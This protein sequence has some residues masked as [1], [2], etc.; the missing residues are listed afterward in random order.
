MTLAV[1]P[2]IAFLVLTVASGSPAAKNTPAPAAPPAPAACSDFYGHVNQAWLRAHPL[3]LGAPSFSRWDELNAAAVQ[4]TQKLLANTEPPNRGAASVLLATLVVSASDETGLDAAARA[5]AKPL[6]ARID[7]IR[8]PKDVARTIA[9]LHAAGVPVVFGFDALR[10]ADTG[11]ARATFYPGG[12]GLPDPAYYGAVGPELQPAVGLYRAYLGELL[13]FAGV[14][15]AQVAEQ[16]NAAWAIETALA[17]T[18]AAEKDE[19]LAVA[20]L[21]KAYPALF[22]PDFM[23]SQGAAPAVISV[24]GPAFFKALDRMLAK[25]TLAQWQAYLRTQVANSLAPAMARDLRQPYLTALGTSSAAGAAVP[26]SERLA[27]LAEDDALELVSSAYA[28]TY[29]STADEKRADEI[30]ES[31]RVSMGAAIDRASWLSAAGKTAARTKLEA[32]RLAIG[33]PI[34]PVSF[35]DLSFDR[36]NYAGNLLALRRWNRTRSLARL[37]SAVWPWPVSQIQPVI[38]YQPAE[39]RLI[40]TAAA[41]QAPAF[42]KKSAASDYGSFGALIAQQMSLAFADFSDDDGRAL[43]SRQSGLVAQFDAYTAGG[44]T[45][46]NGLRMLRQNAADLAAIEIA[47]NAFAAKGAPAP[48][49][50]KEFFTAWAGVWA[51]QDSPTALAAEQTESPFSPARWRVNGPLVNTPAFTQAFSCKAGQP[52]YKNQKDQLAIWR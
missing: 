38:G 6:L 4:Q 12:L 47:W 40:V 7:S 15:P 11:Q 31:I 29:L 10:E 27:A 37:V 39:N 49:A 51:R 3:M 18:M 17:A 44:A 34:V 32:M 23:Q 19:S 14:S 1:R 2:L 20:Q 35:A 45:K 46:V 16:A 5:T 33:K 28:E 21:A 8:K 48:A 13:K 43:A 36:A 25:P 22:L 52:M 41:L 50:Q 24:H 30:G 42:E 9:E 26:V